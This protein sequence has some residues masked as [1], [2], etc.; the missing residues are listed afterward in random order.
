ML[1][2]I[3]QNL[4]ELNVN[5]Y[6]I[7]MMYQMDNI[8]ELLTDE[9]YQELISYSEQEL[10]ETIFEV[11]YNS[12]TP[13]LPE[14]ITE[15]ISQARQETNYDGWAL[16]SDWSAVVNDFDFDAEMSDYCWKDKNA[17]KVYGYILS[18]EV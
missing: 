7:E 6:T 15:L 8:D 2:Q 18:L 4:K 17:R 11:Y 3:I 14:R 5:S 9:E 10:K 13:E 1:K 12:E 16:T